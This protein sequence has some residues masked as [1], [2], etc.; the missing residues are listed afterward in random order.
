MVERSSL[1]FHRWDLLDRTWVADNLIFYRDTFIVQGFYAQKIS[2]LAESK[3]VAGAIMFVSCKRPTASKIWILQKILCHTQLSFI[4]LGGGIAV[5]VYA[6]QKKYYSLVAITHKTAFLQGT[7]IGVR[8]T[9]SQVYSQ[10]PNNNIP[11]IWNVGSVLC[12]IIIAVCMTYYVDFPKPFPILR[13]QLNLISW[14]LSR[15]D[16]TI[17]QTKEILKKIIR[18][19]IGTGSLTGYSGSWFMDSGI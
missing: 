16:T 3:K 18:L 6:E 1:H 19:T 15:Y 2:I 17:K 4:Q 8:A 14:Q 11:Q 12:D 13:E 10:V 7:S 5:G 9:A